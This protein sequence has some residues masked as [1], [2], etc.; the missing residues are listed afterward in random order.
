MSGNIAVLMSPGMPHNYLWSFIA[1]KVENLQSI[2]SLSFV[3]VKMT[4]V[5]EI[6]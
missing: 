5:G 1:G 2:L 4:K 3:W 6:A